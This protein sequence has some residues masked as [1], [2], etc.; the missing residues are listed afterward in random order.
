GGPGGGDVGDGRVQQGDRRGRAGVGGDVDAGEQHR[1]QA[2]RRRG[3]EQQVL[4]EGELVRPAGA[5]SDLEGEGRAGGAVVGEDRLA[6]EGRAGADGV[7]LG[8][9]LVDL[10]LLG[11]AVSG[12]RVGC[13]DRQV[14]DA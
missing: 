8:V 13:G 11:G 7:E 10:R 6:A 2:R 4:A 12:R 1:E 3:V 5:G 14:T 9:E